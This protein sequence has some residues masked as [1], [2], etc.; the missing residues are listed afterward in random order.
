LLA[1]FIGR[2][3]TVFEQRGR[4]FRKLLILGAAGSCLLGLREHPHDLA[5]FNEY[6]GGPLGG[7]QLLADSNIDWGQ[8][9]DGLKRWINEKQPGEI[10]LAYF[11]TV[12][13]EALGIQYHL[14]PGGHP[15]PG[16]Y[17]I[18]VNYLVGRPH[19][20]RDGRGGSRSIDIGEFSYFQFFKPIAH[21][22]SSI[23]VFEINENDVARWNQ[24]RAALPTQ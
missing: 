4:W 13:P 2:L 19:T 11:G 9:L 21:I 16:T 1:V 14:P 18:S 8:D 24:A 6:A 23:D 22:G 3:G 5:Y 10:G 15:E 20:A 17:A 12:P 7:R